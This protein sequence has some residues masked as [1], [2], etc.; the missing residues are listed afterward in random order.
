MVD[1]LF[2]NHLADARCLI[3][4]LVQQEALLPI[5]RFVPPD[6]IGLPTSSGSDLNNVD[7]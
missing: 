5:G 1:V 3:G 4:P 7:L 2:V 6:D